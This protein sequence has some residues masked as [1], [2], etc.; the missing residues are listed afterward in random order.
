MR[1]MMKRKKHKSAKLQAHGA[2]GAP[3]LLTFLPQ[4]HQPTKEQASHS[5]PPPSRTTPDYLPQQQPPHG[6]L[7]LEKPTSVLAPS[8]NGCLW[9]R[10]GSDASR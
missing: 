7:G 10:K 9:R 5:K 2:Q 4:I 3:N 8:R 6:G 1:S